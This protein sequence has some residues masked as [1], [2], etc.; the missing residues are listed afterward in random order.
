[1]SPVV[2]TACV[3]LVSEHI[4]IIIMTARKQKLISKMIEC[5]T[6]NKVVMMDCWNGQ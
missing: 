3:T 1:M 6:M 2:I 4:V 5:D